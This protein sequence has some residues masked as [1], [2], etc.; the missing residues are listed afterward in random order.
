LAGKRDLDPHNAS[1]PLKK[2]N[3][4]KSQGPLWQSLIA[5]HSTP[6]RI[7]HLIFAVY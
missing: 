3:R 7:E 5:F 6:A 4:S 1:F 2:G